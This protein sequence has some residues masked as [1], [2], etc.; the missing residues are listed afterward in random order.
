VAINGQKVQTTA[1]PDSY[2]RIE[3]EWSDGDRITL[4]LP[5]NLFLRSWQV[6]Q[7]SVSVNYGPLTFSLKIEEEYLKIDNKASEIG[8]SK[9]QKGADTG[10]WPAYA[11][12]PQSAWNYGLIYDKNDLSGSFTIA[13][14]TW[15]QDDYPFS[16]TNVPVEIRAK[17]CQVPSWGID[18][19]GLVSVLPSYPAKFNPVV[20]NITLI[21]MGAARLRISAFPVSE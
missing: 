3:R 10:K 19:Y 21:P 18:Q 11:I 5:M 16:A 1:N 6:N 15:P 13:H 17:G 8:D 4:N 12:I 14:K 9:W 2:I 7:N 20:E